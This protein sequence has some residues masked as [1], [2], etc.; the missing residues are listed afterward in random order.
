[1]VKFTSKISV[2]RM[3][4]MVLEEKKIKNICNFY[5]SDY[6]LEIMLLPY[7]SK[8]IDNEEKVII[9]T[10]KDLKDS[11]KIVIDRINIEEH[12]KEKIVNLK[13]N[14]QKLEN[15]IENTNII[16]IG[17]SKFINNKILELKEKKI[18][19]LTII[20]C[21]DYNEVKN[22]IQEIVTK[23]DEILNTLGLNNI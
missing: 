6:H 5:V 10:E 13:W 21:Y 7:I 22:D 4:N 8:K 1:M 3:D 17:S 20:A 16:L 9:I 2:E 15:I 23:Y 14:S 12:K 19:N 11:L 18:K